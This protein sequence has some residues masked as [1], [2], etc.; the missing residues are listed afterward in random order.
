MNFLTS[1]HPAWA[2]RMLAVELLASSLL[3]AAL[4]AGTTTAIGA[5]LYLA[6]LV[7]WYWLTVAKRLWGLMPL[8]VASTVISV[9]NLFKALQ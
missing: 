7:F 6:S 8:N 9:I 1:T 4:Y 2:N 5:G 3:L